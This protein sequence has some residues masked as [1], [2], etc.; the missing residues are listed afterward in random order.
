MR[1]TPIH[2]LNDSEEFVYAY[3]ILFDILNQASIENG[4]SGRIDDAVMS[5]RQAHVFVASF[6][7]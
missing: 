6:S 1:L 7:E 5:Y 2:Y 4:L 3:K